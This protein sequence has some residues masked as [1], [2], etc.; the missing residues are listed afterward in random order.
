MTTDSE[1][2]LT[3][4][5]P[6]A[7]LYADPGV[8]EIMVDTPERVLVERRGRLED[9]GLNLGSPEAIRGVIDA[10]LALS[11]KWIQPGE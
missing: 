1:K 7:Q 2:I 3:A 4:L 9:A 6:L 11:K 8:L 5:G 10:L